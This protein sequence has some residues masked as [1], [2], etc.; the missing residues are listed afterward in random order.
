[1]DPE[2]NTRLGN[3]A[4]GYVRTSSGAPDAQRNIAV[5]KEEVRR[6]AA[7]HD[8][9]IVGWYVDEGQGREC[10]ALQRL[11]AAAGFSERAFGVV[12]VWSH[13]R[14]SRDRLHAIM[15]RCQLWDAG[16]RLLSVS[17][18]ELDEDSTLT[19]L[20]ESVIQATLEYSRE[21]H[22]E[23]TRRGIQATR[24]GRGAGA[25]GPHSGVSARRRRGS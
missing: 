21:Q 14:L 22:R 11:L 2:V 5:Q 1:M 8:L 13:S 18:P 12:L 23:A 4:V 3:A 24:E 20:V 7:E 25:R 6:Y 19:R 16:V 17:E 10:P 15:A 9:E